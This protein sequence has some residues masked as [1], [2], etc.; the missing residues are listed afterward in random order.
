MITDQPV[1]T[2]PA[3]RVDRAFNTTHSQTITDLVSNSGYRFQIFSQ[4]QNGNSSTSADNTFLTPVQTSQNNGGGSALGGSLSNNSSLSSLTSG[5]SSSNSPLGITISNPNDKT[6][7]TIAFTNLPAIK[8]FKTAPTLTGVAGDSIA[9][10]RVEYSTDGGQDWLPVDSAQGLNTAQTSFS[11][12]P[13]NL[14]DGTYKIMARA[15]NDGGYITNTPAV[16]IVLD[17]LPPI[18]GGNL[19]SLGPQVLA[20]G[21]S[22]IT[23]SLA[24]VDQKI[25][26]SAVGGPTNISLTAQK[27]GSKS[28]PQVFNLTKLPD[29]LLWSGIVSIASPGEYRLVANAVDGAG[30]KTTQVVSTVDIV[31][32][33]HTYSAATHKPVAATVTLYYLAPDTNNWVV[34]DGSSYGEA[35]PQLTGSQGYFKLF[36]P[37]GTYYLKATAP[38]YHTLVSS[39]FKTSQS[40]P[41]A[42]NLGLKPL[43]E[44]PL[45]FMHLALPS[46][47]IQ[48]ISLKP[49]S[50]SGL[51]ST[52]NSLIGKPLPDFSLSDTNGSVIHAANL[53]GRPTLIT[54]GATW[55][56]SMSEQLTRLNQLQTNQDLNI[57]PVALQQNS[58]QVQAY[59]SIAGLNLNWLVDPDSALTPAYG[60]PNLPTQYFVDRNGIVREIYVGVLNGTQIEDVL[61]N[62]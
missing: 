52:G 31:A 26:L 9:V 47:S 35:N 45:G 40:E 13:L 55:S 32:D 42:T 53:L 16:T 60:S 49:Q 11:F 6:P 62:L 43:S 17:R 46:W 37:P 19:L 7:P 3:R 59:T 61:S 27:A 29:T 33:P 25:T 12:T 2:V 4:D 10:Q 24:G 57:I 14:P 39:I 21:S 58:G 38:G 30:I 51:A 8:V 22:G 41:L 48:N 56:P 5:N 23:S 18:V 15:V 54:L 28:Q 1:I 36:V 44:L 50:V 20:P 34:W